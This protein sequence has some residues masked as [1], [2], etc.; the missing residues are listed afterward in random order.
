MKRYA[1]YIILNAI[2]IVATGVI[3]YFGRQQVPS[4]TLLP[5]IVWVLVVVA[6]NL[7][8]IMREPRDLRYDLSRARRKSPYANQLESIEESYCEVLAKEKFFAK[9]DYQGPISEAYALIKKQVE[10]NAMSALDIADTH[11][12]GTSANSRYMDELEEYSEQLVEKQDH[13]VEQAIRLRSMKDDVD[14][15]FVADYIQAM[16]AVLESDDLTYDAVAA[17]YA[18]KE[19]D[20]D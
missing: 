16:D 7:I 3:I 10:S 20:D 15:S 19:D 2:A 1:K 9:K 8:L 14:T 17:K 13:L 5:E 12:A 18:T 4:W 6:A 11:H